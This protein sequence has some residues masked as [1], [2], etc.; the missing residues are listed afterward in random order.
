VAIWQ[1]TGDGE[2]RDYDGAALVTLLVIL[3]TVAFFE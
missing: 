2:A 1:I 3:G